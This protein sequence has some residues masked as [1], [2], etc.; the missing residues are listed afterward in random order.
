MPTKPSDRP[1]LIVNFSALAGGHALGLVVPLLTV[2]YLARVLRPEGW[3]PVLV[4]QALA[5]WAVLLLDY[6]F[7]LSATRAVAHAR[8]GIRAPQSNHALIA[9]DAASDAASYALGANTSNHSP[10]SNNAIELSDIVWRVQ[11]AKLL[12]VPIVLVFCAIAYFFVPSLRDEGQLILWTSALAVFRGLNPLWFFQGIERV[13]GA[14]SID[15]GAKVLGALGVFVFVHGANDGWKVLALQAVF[16]CASTVLLSARLWREAPLLSL[17]LPSAVEALRTSWPLFAFRA[18]GT[19]YMQA[20]T[21]ILSLFAPPLAVAAYGGAERIVRAA[22]NLLEPL[23]RLFLP[24]ISFLSAASPAEA[25]QMIQ[26]C[27]V[28]LT[29]ASAFAGTVIA[30]GAPTFVTLMLGSGYEAAIPVLRWLALLLPTIT[31]GTVLGTFW[32]LPFKRDRALLSATLT[33]GALNL[34]LA[35]WLV[36]TLEALGMAAAVVSAE[37]FV[38][39][40][41]AVMY[42]KWRTSLSR[43]EVV[44]A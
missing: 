38:A 40:A 18:S 22:L 19:L 34:A 14:V 41:L 1:S 26:R 36:P 44:T 3:A 28:A 32:A 10:S 4:A 27:L 23:I 16:A 31:I 20:N 8:A 9:I 35:Y 43:S 7:D 25:T 24:R 30:I 11:H 29:I 37:A 15:V 6:G 39:L 13:R 2:P 33:A 42:W 21:I 5:S 17:S 12:L